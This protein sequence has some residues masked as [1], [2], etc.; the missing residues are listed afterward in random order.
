MLIVSFNILYPSP[1]GPP[2][3]GDFSRIFASFSSG[4]LGHAF[5][6][7]PENQEAYQKRFYNFYHRFW[8]HDQGKEG[9]AQ[10]STSHLFFWPGW[11]L[12][13]TPGTFDLAWNGFLLTV[14]AGCVV[15]FSLKNVGRGPAVFSLGVLAFIF[16]DANISGYLNSF[17]QESGAY[18]SF[19]FLVCTLHVFWIRRNLPSLLI[20]FALSLILAGTKIAY[21]LSVLPAILPLLA[22]VTLLAPKNLYLRRYIISVAILLLLAAS[23]LLITLLSTT[24]GD[25]RRACCYHFIFTGALPLLSPD[26]GK[27]YLHKLRLDPGLISLAGK[28]AFQADSQF[29]KVCSALTPQLHI[30]SA[31]RLALDYPSTFFEMIWFSFSTAGIYPRLQY[32][33]LS[34]PPRVRFRF[35][36]R[37]W[38]R[39]HN[40]FLNGTAYYAVVLFLTSI[41]GTLIWRRK[42]SGWSLFYFL[43]AA[44]FFPASVLQVVISVLGNGPA[45]IFKHQFFAN[46]LLD[47][48]FIFVVCGLTSTVITFWKERKAGVKD[49][50]PKER[51]TDVRIPNP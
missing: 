35:Q 36:W 4:P 18:L 47:A 38:S 28:N 29:H 48:A 27:N 11:F 1:S 2:D 7:S 6:P 16:A 13:L 43:A 30:K 31:A 20:I 46:L 22:G 3:N 42:D 37:F 45:D 33:S 10:L 24:S 17:Y 21:T 8:R 40:R 25:L 41:L 19:L 5:W 15:Y 12:N 32:P 23:I 26:A 9:F 49:I 39:L 34:D 44:G 51:C 14:L 50:R